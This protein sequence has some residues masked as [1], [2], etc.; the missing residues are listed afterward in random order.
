MQFYNSI[1]YICDLQYAFNST[2][3]QPEEVA[4][5]ESV[6]CLD[7]AILIMSGVN[8]SI[9]AARVDGCLEF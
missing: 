5:P 7:I 9:A 4:V 3:R 2:A 6:A 8:S 1:V